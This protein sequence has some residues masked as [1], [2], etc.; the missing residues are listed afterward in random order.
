M[1]DEAKVREVAGQQHGLVHRPGLLEMGATD[2]YIKTELGRGR[3]SEMHPGVYYLN[4]TPITWRTEVLAAVFAAGRRALASHRTAA[5][6]MGMDGV[7]TRMIEVCVAHS[8]R[9]VPAGATLHRSRRQL[10]GV[11][12]DAIPVTEPGRT[13]LDLA[14]LLPD[15]V[16][17]KTLSSA[18]RLKL[19]TLEEVD[20]TIGVHGG[21]GVKGTRRLRRVLRTVDGDITGSPSEV[22][23]NQLVRDAPIPQPVLQLRIPLQNGE[24]AYPDFSWPDR[25]RIVEIDGLGAHWTEEQLQHDLARQNQ[26]M[27]LGWEIRRFT[28]RQLRRDPQGVLN[29]IVSFVNAPFER[30]GE[31]RGDL[32]VRD[33]PR[34]V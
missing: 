26:L 12:F 30:S 7:S 13:L 24:N 11:M 10:P 6:L 16:L 32:S 1:W 25:M 3:W 27:A 21:R 34:T 2:H 5:T 8:D 9:P 22:D 4:V 18:V 20:Q 28:A 17:E 31:I 29:E 33:L 14:S 23:A 15:P 19:V